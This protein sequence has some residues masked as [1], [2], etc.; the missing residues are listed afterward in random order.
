MR[1]TRN[2]M[3]PLGTISEYV[4]A[5]LVYAPIV[6]P[7]S[8]TLTLP[9]GLPLPSSV[10]LPL[11]RRCAISSPAAS[12]NSATT[13]APRRI[14]PTEPPPRLMSFLPLNRESRTERSGRMS[15]PAGWTVIN[16]YAAV[17]PNRDT[18][19]TFSRHS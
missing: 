2:V 1:R 7:T 16:T 3:A 14:R 4:P 17:K 6:V 13:L 5:S 15:D 18:G 12:V 10:T 9:K 11:T 8:W 19:A